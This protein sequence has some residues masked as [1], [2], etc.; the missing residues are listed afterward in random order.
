MVPEIVMGKD[1][2]SK[3]ITSVIIE[4]MNLSMFEKIELSI[5]K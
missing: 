3:L 2:I 5:V 1:N 4:N